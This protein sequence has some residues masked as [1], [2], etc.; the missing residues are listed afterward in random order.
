MAVKNDPVK[1]ESE[2]VVSGGTAQVVRGAEKIDLAP[3][4]KATIPSGGPIQRTNLLAPPDLAQ[5]PNTAPRIAGKPQ[6]SPI[7]FQWKHGQGALVYT[8]RGST[9]AMVTQ[10][11]T[12]D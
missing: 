7:P 12:E 6:I 4:E 1:K 9:T 11:R 3:W 8:L 5:P 2:I 10:T